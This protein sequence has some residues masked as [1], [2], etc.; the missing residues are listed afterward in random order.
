MNIVTLLGRIGK[1]PE[2]RYTQSGMCVCNVSLATS[3][4]IKG[5]DKTAWHRLVAFDKTAEL[6]GQY[7]H[8]GD[9]LGVEGEISYGSYDKDGTTVYTTDIIVNRIHFVGGKRQDSGQQQ[10]YQQ[11]R[12]NQGQQI[13][14]DNKSLDIPF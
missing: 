13:P 3:K 7:V 4:K 1:E 8:K 10:G 5:E 2:T 6:I 12:Q 11:P 14:E 9:Q